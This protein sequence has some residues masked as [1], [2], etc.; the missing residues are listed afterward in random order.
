MSIGFRRVDVLASRAVQL[1]CFLVRDIRET[2]GEERLG[3]AV[4]SRAASEVGFLVLLHL[5]E[6]SE[7]RVGNKE[8]IKEGEDA[9]EGRGRKGE[10]KVE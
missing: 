1:D 8:G 2:D 10:G 3:V 5:W 6:R 9:E 7:A 4:H